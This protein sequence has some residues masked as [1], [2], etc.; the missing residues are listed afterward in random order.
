MRFQRIVLF[1]NSGDILKLSLNRLYDSIFPEPLE[2]E[3]V[4]LLDLIAMQ[5]NKIM[6]RNLK[7]I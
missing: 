2:Y 5:P 4:A 7:Q 1:Q 3:H 6:R